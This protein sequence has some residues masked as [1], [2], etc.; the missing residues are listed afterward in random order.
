[1]KDEVVVVKSLKVSFASDLH[2]E[3]GGI[4]LQND[5]D[6]DLLILAGDICLAAHI[7]TF[8][9]DPYKRK[10]YDTFFQSVSDGW[11]KVIYVFG[12]HE[13]YHHD[14]QDTYPEIRD[15]LANNYPNITVFDPRA[16]MI[17][18]VHV[19]GTTL[20]S[21]FSNGNPISMLN[22][23][24][25]MND[26]RIIRNDGKVMTPEFIYT[27]HQTELKFIENALIQHPDVPTVVVTHHAPSIRSI[28]NRYK[29][30]PI[31]DAY[32]TELDEFIMSHP[33]IQFW[34][35]G[36]THHNVDYPVGDHTRVVSNQRGY[37]GVQE[38][39]NHFQMK[40][41]TVSV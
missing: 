30:D 3:F 15:Y 28:S 1:M 32:A 5:D 31:T 9:V 27:R 36:H 12:N 11:K 33:Q 21:S 16:E 14:Y 17:D 41:I 8:D 38:M 35:H 37:I 13:Y 24:Q 26:F 34:I 23:S 4:E 7:S 25:G 20:W 39:A 2:I 29:S 19:I 18:G 10:R 40:T 22:A 6:S